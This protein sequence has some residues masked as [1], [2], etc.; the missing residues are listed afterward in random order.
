MGFRIRPEWTKAIALLEL[1][2]L[3]IDEYFPELISEGAMVK[4]VQ[5]RRKD[6]AEIHEARQSNPA[7]LYWASAYH[8]HQIRRNKTSQ[9]VGRLA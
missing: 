3:V 7:S 9:E 2:H 8:M 5:E 1:T 6:L 4:R